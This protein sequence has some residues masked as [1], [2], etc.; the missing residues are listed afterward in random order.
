MWLCITQ[1]SNHLCSDRGRET[2]TKSPTYYKNAFLPVAPGLLGYCHLASLVQEVLEC[3]WHSECQW[4]LDQL[5]CCYVWRVGDEPE[6]SILGTILLFLSGQFPLRQSV[7]LTHITHLSLYLQ[8]WRVHSHKWQKEGGAM[9]LEMAARCGQ[10]IYTQTA[11]YR[12]RSC[13]RNITLSSEL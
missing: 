12:A 10:V 8:L 1:I 3:Q 4:H 2:S 6:P 13:L 5:L 9:I 7:T 11:P